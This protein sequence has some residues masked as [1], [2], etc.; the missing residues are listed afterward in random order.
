MG[1]TAA[2]A[3]CRAPAPYLRRNVLAESRFRERNIA[4]RRMGHHHAIGDFCQS[5][6]KRSAPP[7]R[8]LR[9]LIVMTQEYG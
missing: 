9:I 4:S 6:G 5:C 8:I 7:S 3:I 2:G 1:R